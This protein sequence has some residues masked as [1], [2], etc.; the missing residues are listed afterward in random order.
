MRQDWVKEE[1]LLLISPSSCGI[2]RTFQH[3]LAPAQLASLS[4]I[5]VTDCVAPQSPISSSTTSCKTSEYRAPL[6][7]G[8][9]ELFKF[10]KV[11]S[12]LRL[13]DRTIYCTAHS[14]DIRWAI[15]ATRFHFE[16]HH[17]NASRQL[18]C[19]RRKHR[20]RPTSAHPVARLPVLYRESLPIGSRFDTS[21][22]FPSQ[23]G[24][25]A[26]YGAQIILLDSKIR[27]ED[28]ASWKNGWRGDAW[29]K[30]R[31]ASTH[32]HHGQQNSLILMMSSL[33]M[34]KWP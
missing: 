29:S 1:W 28:Q 33:R 9:M 19:Q 7:L 20:V 18:S 13:M 25:D 31:Q 10:L 24:F 2:R 27:T 14:R 5:G 30:S 22:S 34:R 23:K 6:G 21:Q 15:L 11:R 3:S 32:L 8:K 12:V 26:R 16:W 4:Y 17:H